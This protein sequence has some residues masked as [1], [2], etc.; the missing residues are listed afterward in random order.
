VL[1]LTR[2]VADHTRQGEHEQKM[3]GF[4][5]RAVQICRSLVVGKCSIELP[6]SSEVQSS[7]MF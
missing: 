7:G 5:G 3:R 4:L 1:Q 6:W 2:E